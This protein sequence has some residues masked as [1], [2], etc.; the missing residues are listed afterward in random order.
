MNDI[1]KFLFVWSQIWWNIYEWKLVTIF[2]VIK[3]QYRSKNLFNIT[4]QRH[5]DKLSHY[6]E[7]HMLRLKPLCYHSHH[8]KNCYEICLVFFP[9]YE[10]FYVSYYNCE[11]EGLI[12]YSSGKHFW[13]TSFGF[14]RNSLIKHLVFLSCL[15]QCLDEKEN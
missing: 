11:D 6:L 9:K 2:C 1:W 7:H 13:I 15:H 3:D 12:F 4:C 5:W 8:F 14:Y 10:C